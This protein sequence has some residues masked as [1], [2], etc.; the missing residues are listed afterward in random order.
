MGEIGTTYS[1]LS[2]KTK[3][4]FGHGQAS[5]ITYMNVYSNPVSR[6][7]MVEPIEI[8]NRQNEVEIGDVFFTT[9]SET[10]EEVGMTSVLTEKRGI[11]YLN[12]FCFGFRPFEKID[13]YY[14]AYMLRSKNTRE[15]IILLAQGISRY[16]IS[17]NKVMEISVEVP[18]FDEQILIGKKFQLIDHLITLHQSK[19][20]EHIFKAIVNCTLYW[21]QRKLGEIAE[22][23]IRKNEKLEST[24]PLTISAQYGLIDQNEFFDK[25][26]ASKDVRGYYLIK[27]GEFAYNK[28]TSVDAPFGAIKRLDK[29]KNGVLSTLYILFKIIDDTSTGSDYLVTYYATDLWHRGIQSIAAEGARNH[30]LLNIAPNDFFETMLSIPLNISEQKKVGDFFISLDYL[31]TLHQLEPYKLIFKAIAY[32]II[33]YAKSKP[34]SSIK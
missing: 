17:K 6:C 31:I 9:S 28:S 26:I 19:S 32:R 10:P 16:N 23:I 18:S 29:Y 24:L 25:R 8:D 4:D 33:D 34:P 22:R 13:K 2:G 7:D 21:E 1:G 30:G 20:F 14:L 12:S 11:I 3:D 5:F 27:K 15:K